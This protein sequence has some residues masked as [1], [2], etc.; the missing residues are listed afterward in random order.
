VSAFDYFDSVYVIHM[1]DPDRREAIDEELDR[2]GLLGKAHYCYADRPTGAFN[3]TNMRRAPVYEFAVNLSHSLAVSTA[4]AHGAEYP[5]FIEDDIVFS[6]DA[7]EVLSSA[8]D[9][10]P[11]EWDMMYMGGHPCEPVEHIGENLVKVG[12]FSFAESYTFNGNAPMVAFQRFW[13]N[14]IG[15]PAAM[16]DFI[17]SRFA[18][19]NGYCTYPVITNQPP[20]YSHI[21][22]DVDDKTHL[23]QR[24]WQS[25]T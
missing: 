4:I 6:H 24:G 11:H 20:V 7:E 15:Q 5:L 14:N 25:N 8:I 22:G 2:V 21:K 3:I 10:L 13:F 1:P 17:L 16:Y 23:V 12:R 9:S 18:M 19:D